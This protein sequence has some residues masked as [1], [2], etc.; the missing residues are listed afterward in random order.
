M[1]EWL[2][3]P[4][5]VTAIIAVISAFGTVFIWVG[6]VNSDREGFK[7]FMRK[8]DGNL[9]KIADNIAQ[10]VTRISVMERGSPL[11]LNELGRSISEF[12]DAAN[13]AKG[14]AGSLHESM[15]GKSEYEIQQLCFEYFRSE[16]KPDDEQD[17]KLKDCAYQNGVPVSVVLDVLALEM[18]DILIAAKQATPDSPAAVPA[19]GQ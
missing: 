14:I 18:R 17:A 13:W 5:I 4:L 1:Q 2:D 6:K 12:L 10:I 15:R 9:E 8:V 3:S 16:F 7:I 11:R 19:I